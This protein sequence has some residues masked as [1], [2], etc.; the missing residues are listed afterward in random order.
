MARP[1][2]QVRF[3][4]KDYHDGLLVLICYEAMTVL[5]GLYVLCFVW[6]VG[7]LLDYGL[8]VIT[9]GITTSRSVIPA[10]V[11]SCII[12]LSGH[13]IYL[14]LRKSLRDLASDIAFLFQTHPGSVLT[15]EAMVSKLAEGPKLRR[16]VV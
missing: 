4:F 7:L 13:N 5:L 14:L 10:P 12:R 11:V 1:L 3:V 2:A 16:H 8:R 15:G 6:L 9:C